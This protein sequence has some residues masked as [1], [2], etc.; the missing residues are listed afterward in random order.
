MAVVFYKFY[1]L[2]LLP[3]Y[4]SLP[5]DPYPYQPLSFFPQLPCFRYGPQTSLNPSQSN[6]NKLAFITSLQVP[7]A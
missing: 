1:S 4:L 2:R 7:L 6:L 5:N 3:F